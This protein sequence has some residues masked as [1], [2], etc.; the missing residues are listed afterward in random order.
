MFAIVPILN[1]NDDRFDEIMDMLD[2]VNEIHDADL[3]YLWR[4]EEDLEPPT[5]LE[6]YEYDDAPEYEYSN[7]LT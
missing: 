5:S 3:S 4:E 6:D 1:E 7:S 2:E